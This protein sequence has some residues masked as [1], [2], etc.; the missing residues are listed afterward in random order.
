M[1]HELLVSDV[2]KDYSHKVLSI[3]VDNK[4]ADKLIAMENESV[5][6]VEGIRRS[7][8]EIIKQHITF[9]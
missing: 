1:K 9:E 7:M 2:P 3:V 8:G 4:V 6:V 5:D